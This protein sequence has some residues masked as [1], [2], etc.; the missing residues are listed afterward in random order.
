MAAA[1]ERLVG[2]PI[3]EIAAGEIAA[4]VAGVAVEG[5]AEVVAEVVDFESEMS[6]CG[7]DNR[8]A[9]FRLAERCNITLC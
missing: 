8:L 5:G 2:H 4:V 7:N 3:A 1:E 9:N 6:L